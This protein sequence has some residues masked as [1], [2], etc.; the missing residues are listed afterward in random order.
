MSWNT[1]QQS[2]PTG[3]LDWSYRQSDGAHRSVV[4]CL[5]LGSFSVRISAGPRN[6]DMSVSFLSRSRQMLEKYLVPATFIHI[7]SDSVLSSN[8]H[9]HTRPYTHTNIPHTPHTHAHTNTHPHTHVHTP[10]YTYTHAHTHEGAIVPLMTYG[11]PVWEG[12]ITKNKYLQ[13]LQ[14]AQ[15]LINIKIAKAYRTISFEASCVIAGV[16]PIGL[17]IDGKVQFYKRKHG[18]E[19]SDIICDMPLPVHKWPHPAQQIT[20]ME[21]N[22]A[23]T[24]PIEIYTDGSKAAGTSRD[25]SRHL[26]KQAAYNAT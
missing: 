14:S 7:I 11:A 23:S 4:I 16:P 5:L 13:K 9:T 26:P 21:T 15:R 25:R 19:N 1:I 6:P 3:V 17:I 18:L 8:H 12:A 2:D 24:Y 20:I 22:E 10:T